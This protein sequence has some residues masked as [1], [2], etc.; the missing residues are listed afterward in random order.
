VAKSGLGSRIGVWL[1]LFIFGLVAGA[2]GILQMVERYGCFLTPSLVG[3][4]LREKEMSGINV[5]SFALT[6]GIFG[7]F[8]MF[9]I[10]WWLI[11]IGAAEGPTTL[12]ERLYMGY[13]FTPLGSVVGAV[14]GFVDW[15]IGGAIFAWLYNWLSKKLG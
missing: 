7:S 11:L 12:F 10:A 3:S 2:G 15:G 1:F 9:F 14:W 4:H 8:S 6:T 5:R 13:S